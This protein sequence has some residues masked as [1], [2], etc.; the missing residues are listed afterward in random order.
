MLP[1]TVE[2]YLGRPVYEQV[3]FAVKKAIVAGQL[4]PGERFPSVRTISQEL[5]INPRTAHKV[6]AALTDEGLLAVQPGIGTVVAVPVSGSAADKT[7]L[8]N[9]EVERLVVEAGQLGLSEDQV[10]AAVRRHWR[11]V[12]PQVSKSR[13]HDL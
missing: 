9:D 1:F 10:L 5:K 12:S 4:A 6:V 3:M 8:L 13:S 2:F 11:K 7:A